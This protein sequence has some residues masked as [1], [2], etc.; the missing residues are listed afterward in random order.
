LLRG[1]EREERHDLGLASGE[2]RR[3]VRA[4]ADA[5]LALDR[6]DLLGPAAVR[7]VLVDGDLPPHELLVDRL[8]RLLD[9]A[10]R[11]RVLDRRAL[12]VDRRRPD[13][14]GQL[15]GL[16]DALE[17]KVALRRLQLL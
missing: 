12:A 4:R 17:E 2:E 1:A 5:D 9:V 8:R 3:A 14:E 10:L 13:R 6:A 11:E 16:D 7:P 15:D